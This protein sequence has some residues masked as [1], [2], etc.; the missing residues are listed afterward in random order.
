MTK[1]A[2][3]AYRDGMNAVHTAVNADHVTGSRLR[4]AAIA[5]GQPVH[6][7]QWMLVNLDRDR[8][9]G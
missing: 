3:E 7:T 9:N 8:P 5:S 2:T 1:P 4:G 6:G